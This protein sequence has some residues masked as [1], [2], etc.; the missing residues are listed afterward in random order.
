MYAQALDVEYCYATAY[1]H[2]SLSGLQLVSTTMLPESLP[3]NESPTDPVIYVYQV[4]VDD[5]FP[6][7]AGRVTLLAPSSGFMVLRHNCETSG[8]TECDT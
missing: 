6:T 4:N 7:C 2:L 8:V 1:T 3:R 5:S